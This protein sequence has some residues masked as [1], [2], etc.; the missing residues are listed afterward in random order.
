MGYKDL[1]GSAFLE[2]KNECPSGYR[3]YF[4]LNPDG[5]RIEGNSTELWVD[6]HSF[7]CP[8]C[9][10]SAVDLSPWDP[11][12]MCSSCGIRFLLSLTTQEIAG[13]Q[14]AIIP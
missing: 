6:P 2:R 3:C 10:G 11:E 5:T 7:Q 8:A 14:V 12:F 13:R 4:P 1:K 9:G